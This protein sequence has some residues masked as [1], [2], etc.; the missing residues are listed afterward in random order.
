MSDDKAA[1]TH[2][3]SLHDAETNRQ[4]GAGKTPQAE[5]PSNDVGQVEKAVDG[6]PP[7]IGNAHAPTSADDIVEGADK[8]L[9]DRLADKDVTPSGEEGSRPV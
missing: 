5:T 7:N 6:R 8:N 1:A 9:Y 4:F 2:A 3:P